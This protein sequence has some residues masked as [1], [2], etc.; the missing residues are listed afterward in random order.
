MRLK[1]SL[2]PLIAILVSCQD[3]QTP[4]NYY[5]AEN[6][7][8]T[9]SLN[10]LFLQDDGYGFCPSLGNVNIMLVPLEVVDYPFANDII[11]YL[12]SIFNDTNPNPDAFFNIASYYRQSSYDRL[13]LNFVVQDVY[14]L[15]KTSLEIG[16][17]LYS[18]SGFY[19]QLY[20]YQKT[21]YQEV[22]ARY[23]ETNGE[24]GL[25]FLDSN[26]D[27][28]IDAIW[29]IY[30]SPTMSV[31]SNVPSD[32][33]NYWAWASTN[34]FVRSDIET[35]KGY[36][37]GGY[38]WASIDFLKMGLREPDLERL[39][40]DVYLHETGH[41]FGLEDLYA[42]PI[43]AIEYVG[44]F[45]RMAV[46]GSDFN[47][48]DKIQLG[49]IDPL[50][51]EGETTLKLYSSQ[52]QNTAILLAGDLNWNKTIFDEFLLLEYYTPT[53]LNE[54]A[55]QH[56]FANSIGVLAYPNPGVKLYHVDGRIH[57]VPKAEDTDIRGYSQITDL[58]RNTV[59]SA[60]TLPKLIELVE[61]GNNKRLLEGNRV[62]SDRVL[63]HENDTFSLVENGPGRFLNDDRLNNNKGLNYKIT[64]G[65]ANFE[66]VQITITK[67][68]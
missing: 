16:E 5:K 35:M 38:C 18:P 49:W 36:S 20:S 48:Y 67:L 15:N 31:V 26:N 7:I 29:F 24:D 53:N 42:E 47:A 11:P 30:S 40:V 27:F 55:T 60:I 1:F 12:D 34:F 32:M 9:T 19:E 14:Q 3:N 64:V 66:F 57:D 23:I 43:H 4:L 50:V 58:V 21:I 6:V 25:S 22:V 44:G 41:L 46:G 13:H 8:A 39:N 51:I 37:P 54:F 61:P 65:E 17:S 33:T 62:G 10:N 28:R 2:I 45:D 63:F 56:Y 52:L 68:A 59:I